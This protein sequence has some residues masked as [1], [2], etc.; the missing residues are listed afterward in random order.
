[1]DTARHA[2]VIVTVSER[3][4]VPDVAEFVASMPADLR[5]L[6]VGPV[7]SAMNQYVTWVFCP[8]G[9]KEGWPTAVAAA[10]W[11]RRFVRL[12]KDVDED[13]DGSVEV[14]VVSFGADGPGEVDGRVDGR[15]PVPEVPEDEPPLSIGRWVEADS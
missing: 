11:R 14:A 13:G 8:D 1:M 9:S 12:F 7:D 10:E 6:V 2:A 3:V 15:G 4:T 5:H